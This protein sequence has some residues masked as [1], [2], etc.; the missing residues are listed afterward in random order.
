MVLLCLALL[1]LT[2]CNPFNSESDTLLHPATIPVTHGRADVKFQLMV[3]QGNQQSIRPTLRGSGSASVQ[4]RLVL[5]FPGKEG[6]AQTAI[7]QKNV[8]VSDGKAEVSFASVP[9]TAMIGQVQI[10][11]GTLGGKA[12]FHGTADLKA[13][14]NIV[15][16]APVGSGHAA[17][18]SA[19]VM[20]DIIKIPELIKA[21]P[22]QLVTTIQSSVQATINTDLSGFELYNDAVNRFVTST[23][24]TG[25]SFSQISITAD[26]GLQAVSGAQVLWSKTADQFWNGIAGSDGLRAARVIRQGF[27]EARPPLVTFVDTQRQKFA[28]ALINPEDGSILKYFVADGSTLAHLSAVVAENDFVILSAVAQGVPVIMRWDLS[29]SVAG[30]WPISAGVAWA[31]AFPGI[32]ADNGLTNPAVEQMIFMPGKDNWLHCVVRD[33]ASMMLATYLVKTDGTIETRQAPP[34]PGAEIDWPLTVFP[35]NKSTTVHWDEVPNAE[36]YTLYWSLSEDVPLTGD[37]A[38]NRVVR[39]FVHTELQGNTPYFYRLTWTIN[40]AV[41]GQTRVASATTWDTAEIASYRLVY[42]GN[43]NTDGLAP[44]DA[45]FYKTGEKAVIL[46]NSRNLGRSGFTFAG[47]NTSADGSGT[48]YKAGDEFIFSE[49]NLTLYALWQT[50][51]FKL[52]YDGNNNTGGT[53]PTDAGSYPADSQATVAA[54]SGSLSRTGLVFAG[55][56]T[57]ADGSGTSYQPGDK[58]TIKGDTTLFAFWQ[59]PAATYRVTYDKNG[60]SGDVPVD[61]NTY[62]SGQEVTVRSNSGGLSR[63]GYTFSGWNTKADRSGTTFQP[64]AKFN[65]AS[66][67][68]VLYAKW[69]AN[70]TY[71]V[72]YDGNGNDGGSVPAPGSYMEEAVV[73]V[74]GNTGGLTNG[75]ASFV[76]WNTK[77]DGSGLEYQSGDTFVMGATAVTL[78]AQWQS[79]AGGSGT[80]ENPYLVAN[81]GQLNRVRNHLEAHFRQISDIDLGVAPFN[82]GSGWDPIGESLAYGNSFKGTYDGNGKKILNIFINRNEDYIGLFG[83]VYAGEVKNLAVEN[84]DVTGVNVVAALIGQVANGK[85][86]NCSSSGKVNATGARSGGLIGAASSCE[87]SQLSSEVTVT[88]TTNAGGLVGEVLGL[89]GSAFIKDSSATGAVTGTYV[90][91]GLLGSVNGNSSGKTLVENCSATGAV[92]ANA[93]SVGGLVGINYTHAE[94]KSSRASGKVTAIH[95]TTGYFVEN[96]GGLAGHNYGAISQSYCDGTVEGG[97]K[98]G[99]LVGYAETGSISKC[100]AVGSVTTASDRVGGLVGLA[101]INISDSFAR[102]AVTGNNRVG[103]LV[104]LFHVGGEINRCYATGLVTGGTDRPDVGG[105]CGFSDGSIVASYW[106]SEA[107]GKSLSSGGGTGLSTAAMKT[108]GSYSGW[109]F[110]TVWSIN[111]DYPVLR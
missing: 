59:Q 24:F 97:F 91:G 26:K 107:T 63:T 66:A 106:D 78:Y 47:W 81:A 49:S 22:A 38:I 48:T 76:G 110:S 103:G 15:E 14:E 80:A 77:A 101:Y 95:K 92:A 73:T 79:F 58:I 39:P 87:L 89:S 85:V 108:Q 18:V 50:Q 84:A 13:G 34:A 7:L 51:G 46:D 27:A 11:G 57:S 6:A 1:V 70:T 102:G 99:G 25:Y 111:N 30:S 23:P 31:K 68:V 71:A 29:A 104:G 75:G 37:N 98:V 54:N 105:L 56:N 67:D 53:A 45:S 83:Y 28:L 62:E 20:L 10:E 88:G 21:A 5:V 52:V 33:P 100:Y 42:Q 3:P 40:G 64:G 69:I 17:D 43:Q 16:L 94:I 19:N 55:W 2:G 8:P 82:E 36:Y 65:I 61:E 74:V 32:N 86:S 12:D 109:D 35:G 4:F 44:I 60:G 9:E 41:R 96:V 72:S 90:V 93:H